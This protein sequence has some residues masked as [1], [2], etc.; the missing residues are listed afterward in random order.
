MNAKQYLHSETITECEILE[1]EEFNKEAKRYKAKNQLL[2][3]FF[4]EKSF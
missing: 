4:S 3:K 1:S 2:Y